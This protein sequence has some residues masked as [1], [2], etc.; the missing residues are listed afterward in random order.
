MHLSIICHIGATFSGYV[1][2]CAAVLVEITDECAIKR[3]VVQAMLI[4]QPYE[5][6]LFLCY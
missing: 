4:I 3:I 6:V 1:I 5:I 2:L